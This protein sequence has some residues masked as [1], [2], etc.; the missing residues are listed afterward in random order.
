MTELLI[1][2]L[3]EDWK[4]TIGLTIISIEDYNIDCDDPIEL[5]VIHFNNGRFVIQR[6]QSYY[7]TSC[8]LVWSGSF[9]EH[10]KVINKINT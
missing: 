8:G 1:E 2:N 4:E 6:D 10:L 3:I 7:T 9:N 5:S